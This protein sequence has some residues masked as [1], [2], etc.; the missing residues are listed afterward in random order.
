MTK[1]PLVIL[2][3]ICLSSV[4]TPEAQ[5]CDSCNFFEYSLLQNRSYFGIFY[6]T[7]HFGGYDRYGYSGTLPNTA[8][9]LNSGSTNSLA[10]QYSPNARTSA[11]AIVD[12]INPDH[13]LMHEPEGTG[14]YVNKTD[15]DWETYQTV[16]VRGNFTLKNKWNFTFL[17]PYESNKVYYEKMLDLPNPSRDTTMT[18]HGWGDLTLAADFI[19]YIY[20][21]KARHTFRPGLA[22][23]APTGQARKASAVGGLYDPIIQPGTDAWSYVLRFNYQLFINK[24]GLNAGANFKQSTEG[25]QS[26]QFGNSVNASLVGFHQVSIAEKWLVIPNIG[27]YYESSKEDTW[28]DEN[29]S[30]TGG[31][32]LFG[33]AGMDLNHQD[34]TLSFLYQSPLTQNLNG[35]QIHH[36]DRMSIGFIKAFKL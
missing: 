15:Q 34:W 11:P 33:Q 32:V 27:G 25:A 9:S 3:L 22:V 5:A 26:Y 35:N 4:L 21:S 17:L 23:I 36:Q 2:L 13:Q 28:N 24:T 31:N 10:N 16:E 20:S 14:L 30:L 6:R 12:Q 1:K 8:A 7:R 18:V 19:H 29:Q